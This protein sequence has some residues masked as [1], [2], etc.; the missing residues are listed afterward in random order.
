MTLCQVV[1]SCVEPAGHKLS[2][3]CTFHL[4]DAIKLSK[5]EVLA[6]PA[7]Q[8]THQNLKISPLLISE[9]E[10]RVSWL[11]TAHLWLY[12]IYR[13]TLGTGPGYLS[14]RLLQAG[15]PACNVKPWQ[16]AQNEAMHL[17]FD[18]SKR[19]RH[20]AAH[21][22]NHFITYSCLPRL[23]LLLILQEMACC[24]NHPYIHGNKPS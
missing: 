7:D 23:L 2:C 5:T 11:M 14:P 12:S 16:V 22:L 24:T 1:I 3:V 20:S 6:V 18:Q 4:F 8:S 21:E 10:T 15:L 13:P 19:A 9:R 17:F